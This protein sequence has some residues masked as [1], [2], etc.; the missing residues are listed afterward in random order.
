MITTIARKVDDTVAPD[1][2]LAHG[3]EQG[4][5]SA[6]KISRARPRRPMWSM[7]HSAPLSLANERVGDSQAV[8]RL[9]E[10]VDLIT[11][12]NKHLGVLWVLARVRGQGSDVPRLLA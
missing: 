2:S 10:C 7:R 1:C 12:T 6:A 4:P 3:R 5:R 9:A 8:E 11:D